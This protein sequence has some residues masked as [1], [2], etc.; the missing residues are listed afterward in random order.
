MKNT[1]ENPQFTNECAMEVLPKPISVDHDV[2]HIAIGFGQKLGGVRKDFGTTTMGE[3]T[4]RRVDPL[5][6]PFAVADARLQSRLEELCETLRAK[7]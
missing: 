3:V 7:Y 1:I 2:A 6:E 5:R 4:Y